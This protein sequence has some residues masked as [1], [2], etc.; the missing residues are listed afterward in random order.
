MPNLA[1]LGAGN[2]LGLALVSIWLTVAFGMV[3]LSTPVTFGIL[4]NRLIVG[5]ASRLVR[6]GLVTRLVLPIL[7]LA[8]LVSRIRGL[9][10]VDS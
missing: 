10:R 8:L 3:G 7:S 6:I 5:F 9:P 2:V 1:T 4:A